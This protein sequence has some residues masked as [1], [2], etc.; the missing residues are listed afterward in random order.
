[1]AHYPRVGR[2]GAVMAV[3]ASLWAWIGLLI[4]INGA[5]TIQGVPHTQLPTWLRVAFWMAPAVVGAVF[6]FRRHDTWGW[7]ALSVP[8]TERAVSY[9]WGWV[10]HVWPGGDPGYERGLTAAVLYVHMAA[11]CIVIAGWREPMPIP[12]PD[13]SDNHLESV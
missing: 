5:R 8:A 1:M 13:E 9:L 12:P 10:M 6:M 4:V 3:C 7:I 11:L 2:R